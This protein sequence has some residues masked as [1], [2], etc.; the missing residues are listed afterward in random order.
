MARLAG[1]S[2]P[3]VSLVL[4]GNPRARVAAPT[5][6]RVLDAARELGYRP[7]LVARALVS[8]RSYG[9][10]VIVPSLDNP[11]FTEIV[12]GAESVAAEAGYAMLLCDTRRTTAARHLESL[13]SRLIDGVILD[14][15]SAASLP[16][17]S[18]AGIN[19][20]VVDELDGALPGVASDVIGTGR[21]A[22]QHL[23]GLGHRRLGFIGPAT[24]S[25]VFRLRERG[26]VEVARAAGVTIPSRWLRRAPATLAGG[27]AAM[28][29]LL[30]EKERPTAV[31]C[32][33]DLAA[34]GALKACLTAGVSVPQ[35]MSIVGC[36]D[37]EMAVVVTPELTTVRVPARGLGALAARTLI[38]LIEDRPR[39]RSAALP[40]ELIVRG[41]TA[42]AVDA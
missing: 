32:A 24:E 20:V 7:N 22:A 40:I 12:S 31:F 41:T 26:Y 13:R 34:L 6:A 1:V 5:R 29:A 21:Q 2:Q 11:F 18:L 9:L 38:G 33:N 27:A 30:A 23:L 8:S 15:G 37:I 3:T 39:R 17:D 19:A 4:S 42:R 28:K 35:E 16:P 14:P 10:G 36:D 25:R